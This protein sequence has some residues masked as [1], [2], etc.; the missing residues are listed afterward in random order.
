MNHSP[1]QIFQQLLAD[2]S[3]GSLPDDMND[4]PVYVGGIPDAP[5]ELIVVSDAGGVS[6]SKGM[7]GQK[8]DYGAVQVRARSIEYDTV[9]QKIEAVRAALD[10]SVYKT[11]VTVDSTSYIVVNFSR[12]GPIT[13][14]GVDPNT[15]AFNFVL[16]GRATIR[17]S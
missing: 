2:L 10:S 1:A 13:F 7:T 14:M 8:T 12:T 15:R 17:T 6:G 3:L 4:W 9:W 5:E 11:S 16:N